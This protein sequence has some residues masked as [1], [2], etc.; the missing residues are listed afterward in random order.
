MGVTTIWRTTSK[1][2]FPQQYVFYILVSFSGPS[3]FAAY[4]NHHSLAAVVTSDTGIEF[5]R[6]WRD[7][8]DTEANG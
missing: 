2:N 1:A 5:A 6:I 4:K 8:Q 3:A 7:L